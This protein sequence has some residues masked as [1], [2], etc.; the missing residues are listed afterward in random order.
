MTGIETIEWLKGNCTLTIC[1]H[2]QQEYGVLPA[3]DKRPL[4]LQKLEIATD[5]NGLSYTEKSHCQKCP[6]CRKYIPKSENWYQ[7]LGSY[8]PYC[9]TCYR[10]SK[11]G[12]PSFLFEEDLG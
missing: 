5:K 2:C 12:N 10:L 11:R 9:E 3:K 4:D 6:E 7:P 1:E 8:P